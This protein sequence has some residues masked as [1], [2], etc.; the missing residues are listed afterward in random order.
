MVVCSLLAVAVLAQAPAAAHPNFSGTWVLDVAKSDFAGAPSP[1]RRTDVVTQT[2]TT[3]AVKRTVT[4]DDGD[5]TLETKVELS[6]KPT[7]QPGP[8]GDL[9]LSSKWSGTRLLVESHGQ[10]P[11]G[12]TMV[13]RDTWELSADKQTLTI[14]RHLDAGQGPVDQVLTFKKAA[15]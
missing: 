12:G 6:G 9:T 13:I 2:A 11:D 3:L 7:T 1:G 5:H 4:L 10:G 14:R 15:Q 8:G